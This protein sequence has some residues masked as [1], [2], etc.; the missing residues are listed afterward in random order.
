MRVGVITLAIA[1]FA[2]SAI[3]ETAAQADGQPAAPDGNV[4]E[5]AAI[6]E[7]RELYVEPNAAMTDSTKVRRYDLMLAKAK[8]LLEAHRGARNRYEV[9]GVMMRA[10]QARAV[11]AHTAE[12]RQ[13]MF[14]IARE[15]AASEAPVA[16]RMPA[17]L[18]LTH[19]AI[20]RHGRRS[21]EAVEAVAQFAEKYRGTE[22]EADSAMHAVMM[23]FD[24]GDEDLFKALEYRLSHEFGDNPEVVA[25]LRDRFGKRMDHILVNALLERPGDR[26][27]WRLPMDV[28]GRPVTVTFWAAE[29]E[30]L[31]L[32]MRSVKRAYRENPDDVFLLGVNLDPDQDMARREAERL[33]LDY[34]Q[35]YRGLGASDP[36]F[37][38]FGNTTIPN[39]S[40]IRPD[41]R[42]AS[43]VE[44]RGRD[45]IG[46]ATPKDQEPPGL[47]LTYLRSGEFVVTRPVGPTDPA[48]PP[49]L[50]PPDAARAAMA[51][52]DGPRVPAE[53]LRSIQACFTV[54]PR[55]YRLAG[56]ITGRYQIPDR[57]PVAALYETAVDRCER[58]IDENPDAVDLFLVRN[59]LMVALVGLSA[60]RTKPS[61]TERAAEVGRTVLEDDH[62]P[63]TGKLLAD[64]CALR[65]T[66]REQMDTAVIRDALRAFVA[67]YAGGH[68]EP[69]AVAMAAI[70]AL[71]LGDGKLHKDLVHEIERHHRLNQDMR[72]F[73]WCCE[74]DHETGRELRATIPLLDGGTLHFP[75]D[76]RG[77]AGVV[78][79]IAYCD[80]PRVMKERAER[81][82]L[83][84]T[85]WYGGKEGKKGP[86][87]LHVLYA[88]IGG[89]RQKVQ[90]LAEQQNWPWPVAYSGPGWDDPLAQAYRGPG[91]QK[92][93]S[94]LV[95]DPD[96]II[97]QEKRGSWIN[98]RFDKVLKM[99][100]N[101]R[102]D[103]EAIDAG[104]AALAEGDF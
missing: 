46:W 100:S 92:G 56:P 47:A 5:Q 25:F 18:L 43:V 50:G 42:S 19:A 34:P 24:I 103:A 80:D 71:E 20:A 32:K 95:V 63:Q 28:L 10:A 83:L 97:V 31:E 8:K 2:A 12:A 15:I 61:L 37:L 94:M 72:P 69:H 41:G 4:I 96:G 40:Y 49:E 73:L 78:V 52:L 39:V 98:Q 17:D 26:G 57:E 29:R 45:D 88:V 86:D 62:A 35:V 55:R 84:K 58:A 87:A 3:A 11:V 48:A 16:A 9:R 76:W 91:T 13:A 38:L 6:A 51:A 53:T 77:R 85:H 67:R 79:F 101:R 54:P 70:L 74:D 81:M 65:W 60:I 104:R 36:F 44:E 30:D 1:L 22:V 68:R 89:T 23:A 99:L 7:L 82:D 64:V 66:L 27:F 90:D 75:D 59:R 33:G 93:Y 14:E 21:D 102:R